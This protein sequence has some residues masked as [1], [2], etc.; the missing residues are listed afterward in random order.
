MC[1]ALFETLG[2]YYARVVGRAP[3]VTMTNPE[4]YVHELA[5]VAGNEKAELEPSFE[6]HDKLLEDMSWPSK[7]NLEMVLR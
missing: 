5:K 3:D 4:A 7:D 2:E 1:R 6:G